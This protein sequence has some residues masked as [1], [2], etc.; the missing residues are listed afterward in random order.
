MNERPLIL[1][2]CDDGI[3]SPGLRA[4]VEAVLGLGDV[5]ISA[6]CEQQSGSG[7]SLPSFNDGVVHA[8]EY[9]VDGQR[10]PAFA[11]HGSPAQAV[12]YAL[13]ELVSRKPALCVAGVNSGS[14][15]GTTIT[16]SGTIGAAL[17]AANEG[18]PALAVSL[19]TDLKYHYQHSD[20]IN[21]S[22]ASHF[23]R[24]FARQML[25]KMMPPDVDTI[26]IDVPCDATPATPWRMTRLSRQ[27]FY[28]AQPSGRRSLGDRL[29][30]GYAI[31]VDYDSLEPDSD[32]HALC[33]DRVVSATPLSL[34]L[35]SRVSIPQLESLL[36]DPAKA[37]TSGP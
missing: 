29:R 20:E 8:I 23:T 6:P 5:V 32:I 7:R 35:T 1:T 9:E 30:L 17:E 34:D 16:T 10:I 28:Q 11:V 33:V 21:F 22:T 4:A 19:E 27:R 12:L 25:S 2:T 18:V 14:N 26:K 3:D 37:V 24:L 15:I 13:V 31:V 36:Q